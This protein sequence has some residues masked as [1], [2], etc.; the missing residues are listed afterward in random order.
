MIKKAVIPAA[1]LGTRFLPATKAQPKEMLP[2]IDTPTIQYVVQ[3]AIDSGIDD[4]LIISGKGKRAIEDHFDRNTELEHILEQKGES[5]LATSISR[6]GEMANIHYIRQKQLNG[7]GDAIY[8]ARQHTGD[9]P[10]VVML[11]DTINDA[12]IPVTQ[13]LIDIYNQYH[14][15]IIAVE[16]VPLDKIQMYGIVS[17]D[18]VSERVYKVNQLIEKPRPTQTRSNL[19]V[20]GRY[21]LTPTIYS[22]LEKVKPGK[23]NEIQ[24]TDAIQLLLQRE[25]VYAFIFE[26]KRYDV[27]NKLDYLKTTVEM[28]LKREEFAGQFLDFL[29]SIVA[30]AEKK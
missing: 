13:Q 6:I 8:Y 10:F 20:A 22:M 4:I 16:R 28:A 18:E 23:N 29:K 7:L 24:L 15:T 19:A 27:G 21:I 26:G 3:E 2:I 12:V 30:Q 25:S 14:Q 11:G 5:D 1:G 17:G 9:E